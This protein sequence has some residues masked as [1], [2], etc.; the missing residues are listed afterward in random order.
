M[1][2]RNLLASLNPR[3]MVV[4][5]AATFVG[6]SLNLVPT[7]DFYKKVLVYLKLTKSKKYL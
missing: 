1:S 7:A 6:H 3:T 4:S 2:Y 5:P